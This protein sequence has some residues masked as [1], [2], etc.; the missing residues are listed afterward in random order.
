MAI[1]GYEIISTFNELKHKIN[2]N[3]CIAYFGS[4]ALAFLCRTQYQSLSSSSISQ[5]IL[6]TSLYNH[7][8]PKNYKTL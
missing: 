2:S 7:A 4:R 8:T 1:N 5:P 3:D 6:N